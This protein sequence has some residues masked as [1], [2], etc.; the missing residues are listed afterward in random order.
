V[1][2]IL[3]I[4]AVGQLN[5]AETARATRRIFKA[6]GT[7]VFPAAFEMPPEWRPEL[8][9]LA[10]ELGFTM[11]TAADIEAVSGTSFNCCGA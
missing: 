8:E 5:Y 9:S 11:S 2:D 3:L 10:D 7:H 6:R 4:D 1:L